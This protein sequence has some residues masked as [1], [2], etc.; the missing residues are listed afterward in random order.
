MGKGGDAGGA[1]GGVCIVVDTSL[2]ISRIYVI[3]YAAGLLLLC[4]MYKFYIIMILSL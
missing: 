2:R 1:D 3:M 4:Y